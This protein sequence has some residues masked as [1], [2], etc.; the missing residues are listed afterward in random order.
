LLT[1]SECIGL[2]GE[3]GYVTTYD[4]SSFSFPLSALAVSPGT[5]VSA[6]FPSWR[7]A[8]TA[9]ATGRPTL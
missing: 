9:A 8:E 7:P 6:L 4:P 3:A 1:V 2:N 5:A